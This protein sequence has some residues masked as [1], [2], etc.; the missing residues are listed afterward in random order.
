V[1]GTSQ[2]ETTLQYV[3]RKLPIKVVR[4]RPHFDGAPLES[5]G[6]VDQAG[7]T[8]ASWE[9]FPRTAARSTDAT[10]VVGEPGEPAP[11]LDAF[12]VAGGYLERRRAPI[13]G[14]RASGRRRRRD[15]LVGGGPGGLVSFSSRGPRP[16]V[17]AL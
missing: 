4:D 13:E 10:M 6:V 15:R 17:Y 14:G 7:A 1:S 2:H 12:W 16:F 8:R 3:I 9:L 5:Q 11:L